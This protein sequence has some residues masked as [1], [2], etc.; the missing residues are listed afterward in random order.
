MKNKILPGIAMLTVCVIRAQ[1]QMP[2]GGVHYAAGLEGIKGGALPGPGIYARDD[3]FFYY[4]TS[5]LL[6]D[7]KSYIYQQGPQVMWMTPWKILGA[8]YGMNVMVPLIYNNTSYKEYQALPSG[9]VQTISKGINQFGLGDIEIE[10]LLLAWHLK[11]FDFRAG[12]GFWA[13]TGIYHNTSIVNLGDGLWTQMISLGGV[14]YPD[15]DKSWAFSILNHFECNSQAP[16]TH[17]GPGGF[18][19][20]GGSGEIAVPA[21]IPCSTYTMEWGAS[22]T[23]YKKIDIGVVGYFQEQFMYQSSSPFNDSQVAA[24]G[25]EVRSEFPGTGWTIALR[26]E[27]QFLANNSPQGQVVNL[28]VSKRF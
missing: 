26:Y 10:P 25:P 5:D 3:N 1:A 27:Y 4:G 6:S 11:H 22:K 21:N 7:Y 23:I 24:I 28:M 20:G 13:P 16:G 19:G 2:I 18:P 17:L 15:Q 8:D 9:F 12:Y 14:W